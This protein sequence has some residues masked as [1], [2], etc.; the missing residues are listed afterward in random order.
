MKRQ[1]L[2]A[3]ERKILGKKIKKLRR[4]GL[5][6]ANVY[7]KNL[8][9]IAIQVALSDFDRVYKE[10][11]ETGLV[12]L[13]INGATKPV[14]IKNLQMNYHSNIPLHA[15]F[16]QV[17]LKEKVKTVVP[18]VLEGEPKAVT[19]KL[20]MLLQTL[21]EVEIEALPDELPENITITVEH[22]A[23]IGDQISVS[24]LTAPEGVAIITDQSQIVAKVAELVTEEQEAEAVAETET[25]T[26]EETKT[27]ETPEEKASE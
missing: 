12:D 26:T 14:L 22:L 27:E 21:S 5:L 4:E 8:S 6:P 25:Q 3:E 2:K 24:D 16:Y 7:G 1:Q 11:G 23:A 18:V 20:G 9:S 19:D 15:D 13:N 17:N 10:A